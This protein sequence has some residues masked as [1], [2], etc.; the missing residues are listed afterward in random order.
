MRLRLK[1][2]VNGA[3]PALRTTDPIARKIFRAMQTYGLIVADN[4]SDMYISGTFDVRWNN[5][6][7][8]PAFGGLKAS[9]FEVVKLG[10]KPSVPALSIADAA[11]TEGDV[12]TKVLRFTVRLS[13]AATSNVTVSLAT[14]NGTALSGSDY[15]AATGSLTF[16]PGQTVRTF[17]VLLNGDRTREANET[18]QVV[19]SNAVGASIA[20]ASAT[21]TVSND[22]GLRTGGPGQMTPAG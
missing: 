12:G 1:R 2:S 16:A 11:I 7:L 21:G 15:V 10:W 20:D 8:N 6:T 13:A 17:D 3:D 14:R 9:D 19:L 18:F 5:G 4:G 22:D